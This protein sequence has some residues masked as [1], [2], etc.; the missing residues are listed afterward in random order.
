MV[1]AN[2]AFTVSTALERGKAYQDLGVFW[3]E[4][5]LPPHNHDGYEELGDKLSV[6]IATGE[7][8]YTKY[9][10]ADLIR[11]GGVDVVQPD[12]RRTG[13]VTEWMEIAALADAFHI[14]V[15]SHGGGPGNL[16]M[17]A[18]MPNAIYLESGSLKGGSM[19]E[20]NLKMVDGEVLVP[21]VPGLG[22]AVRDD[23]IKK[24]RI[25]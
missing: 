15:A 21:D 22:T 16:N 23:Y 3:F 1:D 9:A 13:G 19:Y 5:P 7:N 4:E 14:Q 11:H 18:A 8:E 24:H 12:N 20:V 25:A 2:Q 17:L 10:F 6:R